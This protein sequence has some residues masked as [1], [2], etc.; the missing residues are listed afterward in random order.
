MSDKPFHVTAA[1]DGMVLLDFL[2]R[3]LS[4]SRR[5]AKALLDRRDVFV[6]GH[7]I[8]MPKHRLTA[9]DSVQV[10]V[11]QPVAPH[12]TV[13]PVLYRDEVLVIA[14][15]PR[16]RV[17]VGPGGLE[18]QLREQ[19]QCSS[20]CAAHRLDRDTTGCFLLVLDPSVLPRV[21]ASFR[22]RAVDK[23]YDALVYGR[24]DFAKRTIRTP[25]DGASAVTHVRRVRVAAH[26]SHV[27]VRIDTGRTH[28]IRRHLTALGHP[29][30]GDRHYQSANACPSALR[31]INRQMLHARRLQVPHPCRNIMVR[32]TAPLPE[33]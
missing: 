2:V 12:D 8:W 33:P 14:D 9:G 25:L 32:A 11:T 6:C 20:L 29:V 28:Q 27:E 15:K 10:I 23:I 30:I 17:T 16:G 7:R 18:H 5:R 31:D 26:A 4:L 24:I 22:E 3:R 19:L 13:I 21:I 1:E